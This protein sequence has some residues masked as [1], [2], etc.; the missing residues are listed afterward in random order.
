MTCYQ[1]LHYRVIDSQRNYSSTELST[2]T[3]ETLLII[4]LLAKLILRQE[5]LGALRDRTHACEYVHG[6]LTHM[7]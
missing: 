2:D 5:I 4:K 7:L 1:Q 3:S 6:C